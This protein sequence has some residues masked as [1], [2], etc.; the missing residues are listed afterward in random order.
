MTGTSKRQTWVACVLS[1]CCPG[2][3]HL[4]NGRLLRGLVLFLSSLVILPAAAL[5]AGVAVSTAGLVCLIASFVLLLGLWLFAVIDAGRIAARTS[6]SPHHEYQQPLIYALFIAAGISSPMFCAAYIRQNLLEAF[7]L[8]S[9]SMSPA[10]RKGDRILVNK[11]HWRIDQV[12]RGDVVVFKAPDHA[13]R[14]YI[15]RIIGLPGETITIEGND[16]KVNGHKI[17]IPGT[18]EELQGPPAAPADDDARRQSDEGAGLRPVPPGMCFV[19]GDNRGNSND[20][21]NFGPVA[22]GNVLGIVEYIYLPGDTWARFGV[23]Y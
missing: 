10:F 15:K 7:Y 13:N 1:L 2:L 21:R 22:L 12:K 5:F 16:V 14:M 20:S 19:L 4:Y 9:D 8:P 6:E 11:S 23:V 17:T 18:V 3:G